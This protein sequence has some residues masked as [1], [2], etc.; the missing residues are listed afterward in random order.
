[1]WLSGANAV[2]G[3][4]RSRVTAEAKR[5]ATTAMTKGFSQM[6]S[7][8]RAVVASEKEEEALSCILLL[9]QDSRTGT[10]WCG[11]SFV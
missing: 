10:T 3:S 4:A 7:F 11:T 1:M 6:I 8:C 5:Q 9:P 2:V